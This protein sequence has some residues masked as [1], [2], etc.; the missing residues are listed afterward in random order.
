M[1]EQTA[2]NL[3]IIAVLAMVGTLPFPVR[4]NNYAIIF[5]ALAAIVTYPWKNIKVDLRHNS[6]LFLPA[7]LLGLLL[8][9]MLYTSET[10]NGWGLIERSTSLIGLPLLVMMLYHPSEKNRHL[11]ANVFELGCLLIFLYCFYVAYTNVVATGSWYNPEKIEGLTDRRYYYFFNR[12]LLEPVGI[13]P[14]YLGMYL[15]LIVAFELCR[16]FVDKQA[17]LVII[18]KLLVFAGFQLM[19][20]SVNSVIVMIMLIVLIPLFGLGRITLRSGALM[21][22]GVIV[23]VLAVFSIKPIR[24]RFI[25]KTEFNYEWDHVGY[26]NGITFRL[27][28]WSCAREV[29]AENFMTGVGTGDADAALNKKYEEKKF[30][31]GL[32]ET[33][34]AHSQYLQTWIMHGVAGVLILLFVTWMP[35]RWAW[36]ERDMMLGM[37]ALIIALAF[38]T[39]VTLGTQKG[40]AFFALFFALLTKRKHTVVDV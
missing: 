31:F 27:A 1:K 24:Q 39:E 3:R 36:N 40:I 17:N 35:F 11:V 38:C 21:S 33:Y 19:V 29:I 28:T 37:F 14:I 16:L 2:A 25:V 26:W 6:R 22:I 12:E 30:F 34:N 20:G 5:A 23:I 18:L 4:I 9:G 8:I 10:R 13:N 32:L 15:N 7:M